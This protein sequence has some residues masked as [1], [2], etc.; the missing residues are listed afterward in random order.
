MNFLPHR[1]QSAPFR[2]DLPRKIHPDKLPPIPRHKKTPP[3]RSLKS[4]PLGGVISLCK[5][6]IYK[7]LPTNSSG[8]RISI[9][10][11]SARPKSFR[12]M[13]MSASHLFCR[14]H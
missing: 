12:L 10:D 9:A 11:E 2:P 14:A 3:G 13:V 6:N 4:E 8:D 1:H 5:E 7:Y